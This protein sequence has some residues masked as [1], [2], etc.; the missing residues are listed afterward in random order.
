MFNSLKKNKV[1]EVK[2]CVDGSYIDIRNLKDPI[3]ANEI[4]GYGCAILPSKNI[5]TSPVNGKIITIFPTKHAIGIQLENDL[6]LLLHVGIDTVKLKGKGF[7]LLNIKDNQKVKVGDPLIEVNFDYIKGE[8]YSTEIIMV[9]TSNKDDYQ[10]VE[11]IQ[12]ANLLSGDTV[13][14]VRK[15]K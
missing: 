13:Y 14:K 3:F 12:S 2:S 4:I 11:K 6:E 5:I 15:I 8:G 7:N 1:I 9:I 10:V